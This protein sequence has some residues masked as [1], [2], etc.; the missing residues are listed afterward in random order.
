[1]ALTTGE[2]ITDTLRFHLNIG[3][4]AVVNDQNLRDR[5]RFYLVELAKDVWDLAPHWFRIKNGATVSVV[6]NDTE[7]DMPADFSHTGEE[8]QLYLQNFP[9]YSLV[10]KAPD[11]LQSFR[12][13]VGA[14][15]TRGRPAVWT[16]Q[17]RSA[18]GRP[19]VQIWPTADTSYTFIIDGYVKLMPDLVDR[20]GAPIAAV[21]SAT[22]LT[23]VYSYLVTFVTAAGE[24]EAGVASNSITLANQKG[25]LSSIPVSP[26]RSVTARKIYRTA[27]GGSTYGLVT[28]I[29]DNTTTTLTGDSLA[30]GSLGVAPP[31]VLTA[32]TGTEQFPEDAH[33]RLFVMGLTHKMATQSGDVRDLKWKEEWKKDVM[34]FWGE[35]KQGRNEPISMP[36]YGVVTG[37]RGG[38]WPHL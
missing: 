3:N 37:L 10:W 4:D 7:F 32:I 14:S 31:T 27:A 17:E 21:G 29:S 22:G 25:N 13:T 19:Q 36:R 16:L 2:V 5:A 12:R 34:R 23:G 6:A 1:M 24:T 18:T 35:Y 33:E 20:P 28:T 15:A 38:G 9:Y 11:V 26:C 8:M 30:D